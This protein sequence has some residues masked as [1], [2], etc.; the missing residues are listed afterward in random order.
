MPRER[1]NLNVRKNVQGFVRTTKGAQAPT[2]AV[3]GLSSPAS[4]VG[5][6]TDSTLEDASA[7]YRGMHERINGSPQVNME[8]RRSWRD[9]VDDFIDHPGARRSLK[10][11]AAGVAVGVGAVASG[12]VWLAAAGALLIVGRLAYGGVEMRRHWKNMNEEAEKKRHFD[13]DLSGLNKAQAE[14][15]IQFQEPERIAEHLDYARY[16]APDERTASHVSGQNL[17]R[18]VTGVVE[19]HKITNNGEPVVVAAQIS[20]YEHGMMAVAIRGV[21]EGYRKTEPHPHV[22][23]QWSAGKGAGSVD[24]LKVSG[25]EPRNG[26][27]NSWGEYDL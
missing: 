9:K 27:S 3:G 20:E 15:G 6:A 26:S 12:V 22:T 24:E 4:G 8:D 7:Q 14:T 11:T 25:V 19:K 23:F 21:P 1:K 10:I 17:A 16:T 13:N 5:S 2:S 18:E